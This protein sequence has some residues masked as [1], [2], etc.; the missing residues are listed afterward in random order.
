MPVLKPILDEALLRSVIFNMD[1][2]NC[3]ECG[4]RVDSKS[5]SCTHCGALFYKDKGP[6]FLKNLP[7]ESGWRYKGR[8]WGW[9]S[10][11][12]FV[13]ILLFISSEA[14]RWLVVPMFMSFGYS[15]YLWIGAKDFWRGGP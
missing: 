12:Q 2:V 1:F 15:A 5:F 10:L 11:L 3:V 7:N 6:G 13:M 4:E 9:L 14:L 8:N